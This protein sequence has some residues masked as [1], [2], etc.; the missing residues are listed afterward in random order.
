M[1]DFPNAI[2]RITLKKTCLCIPKHLT[3][4]LA[5]SGQTL[6][7]SSLFQNWVLTGLVLFMKIAVSVSLGGGDVD[8]Q[9]VAEHPTFIYFSSLKPAM[10]LVIMDN[11]KIRL[12]W[13]KLTAALICGHKHSHFKSNLMLYYV[14]LAKQ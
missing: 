3:K 13:W 2:L 5:G 10:S 9:L 7:T 12:L 4:E 11:W 8:V 14:P 1:I 6:W